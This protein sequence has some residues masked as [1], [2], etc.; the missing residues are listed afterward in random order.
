[1]RGGRISKAEHE[2]KLK[3]TTDPAGLDDTSF[4]SS[5]LKL[6][7]FELEVT[8]MKNVLF[9]MSAD[10][11]VNSTIVMVSV[12]LLLELEFYLVNKDNWSDTNSKRTN[13]VI[14]IISIRGILLIQ[15]N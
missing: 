10:D 12:K 6:S 2:I 1:M 11:I 15:S 7:Y 13:A 14:L 3:A 4:S 5:S 8:V 9:A